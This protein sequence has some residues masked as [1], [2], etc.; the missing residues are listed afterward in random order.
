MPPR[1]NTAQHRNGAG[2]PA[3][4]RTGKRARKPPARPGFVDPTASGIS[5][6]MSKNAKSGIT[7]S[8]IVYREEPAAAIRRRPQER[9]QKA[10][11]TQR[12]NVAARPRMY[13]KRASTSFVGGLESDDRHSPATRCHPGPSPALAQPA[14]VESGTASWLRWD[15]NPV[16]AAAKNP[17]AGFMGAPRSGENM[18]QTVRKDAKRKMVPVIDTSKEDEKEIGTRGGGEG[19]GRSEAEEEDSDEEDSDEEESDEESG[20]ETRRKKR[21]RRDQQAGRPAGGDCFNEASWEMMLARLAVFKA[22]HGHCKV[23]QRH[24]ADPK[25][26]RWVTRQRQYKKTLDGSTFRRR[27]SRQHL[28]AA[29]ITAGRMAKLEAIGIDWRLLDPG[30]VDGAGW[31]ALRARLAA[32]KAE[33]GHCKVPRFYPADPKLGRW[34]LTTDTNQPQLSHTSIATSTDTTCL[35]PGGSASS[36]STRR[37]WTMTSRDRG[38]H[39]SG[40]PSWKRS[41]S[42]GSCSRGSCERASVSE[43]CC[44]LSYKSS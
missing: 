21:R 13:K 6:A 3:G 20:G 7:E 40:W 17:E 2:G 38:S 37:S 23:P 8:D 12:R 24:P 41:G 18:C 33:N 32:F 15:R 5:F 35:I 25:L 30:G 36:G 9:K 31:E 27:T 28:P 11:S 43:N 14:A 22:E 26:G 34:A 29:H 44:V 42:S 39:M 1:A 4:A 10:H 16:W 19:L